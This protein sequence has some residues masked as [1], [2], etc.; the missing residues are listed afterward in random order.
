MQE[1]QTWAVGRTQ[2]G[3]FLGP[4]GT[5]LAD[6]HQAEKHGSEISAKSFAR[7]RTQQQIPGGDWQAVPVPLKPEPVEH[8][9]YDPEEANAAYARLSMHR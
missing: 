6:I 8:D 4:N 1:Q 5:P 3:P 9:R 2:K 7:R